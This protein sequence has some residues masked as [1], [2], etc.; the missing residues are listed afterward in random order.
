MNLNQ[1]E[2]GGPNDYPSIATTCASGYDFSETIIYGWICPKCGRVYSPST[3]MCLYCESN[4]SNIIVSDKTFLG[5]YYIYHT[6][7]LKTPQIHL[8]SELF[9]N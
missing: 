1:I 9:M 5:D 4:D 6:D 3:S 8:D 7:P 2:V